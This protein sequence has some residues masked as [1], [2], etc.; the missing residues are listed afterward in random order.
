MVQ[1]Q[2]YHDKSTK[3][4]L[5]QILAFTRCAN[6]IAVSLGYKNK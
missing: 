2:T 3:P 5:E 4:P 6:S 1:V